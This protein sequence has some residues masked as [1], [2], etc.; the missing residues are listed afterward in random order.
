M[1]GCL[2]PEEFVHMRIPHMG[3]K[4][5]KEKERETQREKG[6]EREN[7]REIYRSAKSGE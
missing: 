1:I 7:H 4:K 2:N 6:R 3:D 5:E